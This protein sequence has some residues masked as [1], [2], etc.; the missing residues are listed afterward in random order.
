MI[1]FNVECFN[2]RELIIILCY[3]TK[4]KNVGL[5]DKMQKYSKQIN[6]S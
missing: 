2:F 6:N 1:K 4:H 5:E 3:F